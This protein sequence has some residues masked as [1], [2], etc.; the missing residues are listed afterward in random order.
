[1]IRRW[2]CWNCKKSP[3]VSTLANARSSKR[4]QQQTRAIEIAGPNA[5]GAAHWGRHRRAMT[6]AI[7]RMFMLCSKY[8]RASRFCPAGFV[9]E[10][11]GVAMSM[12]IHVFSHRA[13]DSMTAW[14][15]AIKAQD[16][17]LEFEKAP[18]LSS[19]RGFLPARS[20]GRP[21]GF[22]CCHEDAAELRLAYHDIDFGRAWT[23]AL[24][25]RW[26]AS[27]LQCVAAWMAA[28]AYADATGGLVFDPDAGELLT[29]QQAIERARG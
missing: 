21:T 29:A 15:E 19:L 8:Q 23:C 7:A 9:L 2:F 26:G 25:L 1:M 17:A 6:H 10:G 22:E 13:L 4:A 28:A 5:I 11:A 14:Q 27:L 24:S 12:E 3:G 20:G 18:P 16:F